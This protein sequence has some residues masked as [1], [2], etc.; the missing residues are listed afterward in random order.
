[1]KRFTLALVLIAV[2]AAAAFAQSSIAPA[3]VTTLGV[4]AT[5]NRSITITWTATGDDCT[6]GNAASYELYVSTSNIT[7]TNWQ[8]SPCTRL[9]F[10]TSATNGNQDCVEYIFLP[11]SPCPTTRYFAVFLLDGA[12]NRSPISNVLSV[13][14]HCSGNTIPSCP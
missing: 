8:L 10:G 12:G 9:T 7:D 4:G 2:S 5:G 1:M 11:A 14:S 3:K 13:T 6:T